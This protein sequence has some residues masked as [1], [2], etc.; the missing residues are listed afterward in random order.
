MTTG[1]PQRSV[2]LIGAS[3]RILDESVAA[4]R[5]LGY[6]AQVTSEFF[7]DITGRFD[8]THI[9]LVS[10]G[11]QVPADRKAELKQQIAAINPRVIVLETLVGIPG[12]ITSQVQGA[13]T[14]GR[15]HP[16]RAPAC[17]P[18]DHSIRSA[19]ADPAAVKVT[20]S[21]LPVPG[22]PHRRSAGVSI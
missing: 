16:A 18:G 2:L 10:L 8:I 9:D 13:F 3:Q 1:I 11:G 7:S 20:A 5:D 22:R 21:V 19:L 15:Q 6:T 12:L 14:A 17:T 4:L